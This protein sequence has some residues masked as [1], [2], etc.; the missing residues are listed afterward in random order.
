MA[1][2]SRLCLGV[3]GCE[4]ELSRRHFKGWAKPGPVPP[5]AARR[6][7]GAA[8]RNARRDQRPLP[9]LPASQGPSLLDR[10]RADGVVRDELGAV[11]ARGAR[12]RLGNRVGRDD[13]GLASARRAVRD[14]R[15]A[16]RERPAGAEVGRLQRARRRATRFGTATSATPTRSRADE[17]LRPR[18][19]Q[20]AV[21][22]ARHRHRR[23]SSAEGRVPLRAARRHRATTRASPPRTSSPAGC[24]PACFPRSSAP[25]VEAA[26][27]RRRH[28]SIVRRRPVVFR[29]GE[30]PL[31]APVRDDARRRTCRTRCAAAR[32]SSR[33]S[34][35][36]RAD[37]SVH[38]EYA[39]VKLSIGFPP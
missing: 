19:R 6:T 27:A 11:G 17:A 14:H 30:P 12:S 34:S 38:P 33:R 3:G 4:W 37:G 25:R 8:G 22:S 36:D 5:G 2:V 10:R 16:G 23:R 13:C 31:I 7:R 35:F 20:P 24:S 32:G 15:S 28:S 21:L 26:A 39:A 29:E 9:H 1:I 18:A